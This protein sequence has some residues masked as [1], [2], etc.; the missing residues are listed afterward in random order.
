[1]VNMIV[2]ERKYVRNTFAL[3]VLAFV[4]LTASAF[5]QEESRFD[6]FG[7]WT[8]LHFDPSPFFSTRQEGQRWWLVTPEGNAFLSLGVCVVNP[9]GDTEFGTERHPYHENVMAKYGSVEGWTASTRA[10]FKEWGL[11]TLGN[12]SG[13]E[14]RKEIPYTVE[15]GVYGGGWTK[16]SV[17]DFF[18]PA[19]QQHIHDR[20]SAVDPFVDDPYLIGYY[21]DNELP[22]ATDW[23]RFPDLF[24]GYAAMKPEAPGKQRLVNFFRERYGD[25]AKF[26]AVWRS[27]AAD[28]DALAATRTLTPRN[29]ARALPDMEEFV[30]LAAREYFRIA[31]EGIRS[32]DSH[33]LIL[34]CR[35]IWA[36]APH[37]VVR[38]CGEFCDVVTI[39]YYEAGLVGKLALPFIGRTSL[40]IQ[41][42]PSLD[43]FHKLTG[44]PLMVT[45]F[46]F[47]GRESNNPNSYPPGIV[48]QPT[49]ATQRDRAD[50][51]EKYV[52]TWMRQ[53]FFVGYHW[54]QWMDEPKAGRAGDGENGNYGLVRIDDSP[55]NELV[56]RMTQ[57]NR[58]V[59]DLHANP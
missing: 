56:D 28:W 50:K 36:L 39:N 26:A 42:G 29:R 22:W 33:H 37:P 19:V 2:F 4:G 11:N 40:R 23:R 51:F 32:K 20:A 43:T 46:S 54:F 25:F 6:S 45:E 30:Y 8:K 12:W 3:W 59:W 15:L 41:T 52:R 7:G 49:V 48:L 58:A 5:A 55:W 27:D 47:R 53:P 31:T 14:L 17:P 35:F 44:K 18:D 21:L 24:P 10:R 34:G 9:T 1:M 57:I 13:S 16:E 38:A